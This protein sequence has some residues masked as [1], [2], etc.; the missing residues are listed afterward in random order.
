MFSK[1]IGFT[2]FFCSSV[3][4]APAPDAKGRL[5]FLFA[6]YVHHYQYDSAHNDTPWAVG[7]EW[8][9]TESRLD[10][11]VVTFRN[12]FR[13]QSV[14]AD[15]GRHWFAADNDQGVYLKL[16]AGPL[17]GYRGQYEDKVALND[18][19]LAW[20]F[21]PAISYQIRS[22]NAQLVFHGTA[23]L[24]LTFGLDLPR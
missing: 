23:A 13:Q 17:Y 10:F 4:P 16:T 24:V 1:L 15:A 21:V 2:L 8:A 5:T 3:C 18:D 6:P 9:P 12:S 19:G 20:V 7:V 14:Y 11:G 22:F